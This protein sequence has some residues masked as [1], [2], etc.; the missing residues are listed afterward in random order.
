MRKRP[1]FLFDF[2]SDH[3]VDIAPVHL[4]AAMARLQVAF[5]HSGV[6]PSFVATPSVLRE[7]AGH[8]WEGADPVGPADESLWVTILDA[9]GRYRGRNDEA[10]FPH[11]GRL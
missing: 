3:T 10:S 1:G 7:D 6:R 2:C 9:L 5:G 4:G 8:H 11:A